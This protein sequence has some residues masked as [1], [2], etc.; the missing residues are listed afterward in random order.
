MYLAKV[1][2]KNRNRKRTARLKAKLASK[3]KKRRKN[4]IGA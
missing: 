2:P 3:N 1:G 4:H